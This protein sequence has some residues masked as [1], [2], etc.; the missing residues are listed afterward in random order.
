MEYQK[1]AQILLECL[2]QWDIIKQ[3]AKQKGILGI[4]L[5]FVSGDEE[6]GRGTMHSHW[7]CWLAELSQRVRNFLFAKSK[8]EQEKASADLLQHVD[9]VLN[10]SYSSDLIVT[11]ICVNNQGIVCKNTGPVEDIFKNAASKF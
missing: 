4:L 1:Q 6:Q 8:H 5:A 11:H 7:Q 10:A 2:L 3:K 9:A